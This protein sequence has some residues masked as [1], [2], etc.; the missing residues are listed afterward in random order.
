MTSR[1]TAIKAGGAGVSA[2]REEKAAAALRKAAGHRSEQSAC[3]EREGESAITS[4][5]A[6][7]LINR[8]NPMLTT[9]Q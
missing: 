4:R 8:C 7:M 1:Q 9:A 3:N 5:V 2:L 6:R